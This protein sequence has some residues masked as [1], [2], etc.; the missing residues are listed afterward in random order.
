MKDSNVVIFC[1]SYAPD[2]ERAV[3]L[4]QSLQACNSESLPF[5]LSVPSADLPLF[6]NK[7][8]SGPI[9]LADEEIIGTN[10]AHDLA[11][12]LKIPGYISQ[13][14]VKSEFWRIN[15]ADNYVCVDSDC[16]FIR[17]FG[18]HDFVANNGTPFS[19]L[20]ESKAFLEF[21][22]RHKLQAT[23]DEFLATASSMQ[24]EFN[25]SGPLFNFGPFPVIWN[26][27]VWQALSDHLSESKRSITDAIIGNPNEASWY[28]E[29]L[30]KFT[31][32]DIIPV[33]P[34]FK[35]YLYLEQYEEDRK[36]GLG[37]KEL[38]TLYMGIVY[39]SNW[40][41]KRLKIHKNLAYK[42]KR[43]LKTR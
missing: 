33:E 36:F 27:Q 32:I 42:I 31:P 41:P 20:H 10:P 21:C 40:Y 35:A 11:T 7:L 5:Y 19:I 25:R 24:K 2:V 3:Q 13:Q 6:K 14:I 43:A 29:A 30:L 9:Y 18:A 17:P 26:R 15:P 16:R 39:Q 22:L 37:E 28:G 23:V 4:H 38:A 34:L 8:G 1:K 12:L